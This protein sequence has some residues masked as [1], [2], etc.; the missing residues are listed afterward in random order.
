MLSVLFTK[1][2]QLFAVNVWELNSKVKD[3]AYMGDSG[4]GRAKAKG[5]ARR[6]GSTIPPNAESASADGGSGQV[7]DPRLLAKYTCQQ[8]KL[9]GNGMDEE[10]ACYTAAVRTY[11][12]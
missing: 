8:Y 4:S 9:A 3:H 6:G 12:M 7:S 10:P 2:N 11:L 1:K 5:S